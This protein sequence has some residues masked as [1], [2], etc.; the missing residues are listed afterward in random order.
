[1]AKLTKKTFTNVLEDI[2][3]GDLLK[4]KDNI[5]MYCILPNKDFTA[6][7]M[8][9][10][11]VAERLYQESFSFSFPKHLSK[12]IKTIDSSFLLVEFEQ[13]V[14]TTSEAGSES[15]YELLEDYEEN[16][17]RNNWSTFLVMH[18]LNHVGPFV[19]YL[20]I[21]TY[22][23]NRFKRLSGFVTKVA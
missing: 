16:S 14:C 9:N 6:N 3:V 10:E 7:E 19:T 8:M 5:S 12:E 15:K 22:G 18:C 23:E 1:M 11:V 21:H 17:C 2:Q 4:C 20:H 13:L